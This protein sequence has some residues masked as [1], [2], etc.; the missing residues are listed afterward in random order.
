[1]QLALNKDKGVHGWGVGAYDAA[2]V[3]TGRP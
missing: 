3:A 2:H 1:V